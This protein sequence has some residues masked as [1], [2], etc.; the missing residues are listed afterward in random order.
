MAPN[1][2]SSQEEQFALPEDLRAW[3]SG[4]TL[5]GLVVEA[6]QMVEHGSTQSENDSISE[7]KR[8]ALHVLVYSYATGLFASE[9]IHKQIA[10]DP[11]LV[12]L[13]ANSAP[14]A[15]EFRRFRRNRRPLLLRTLARLLQL[16]WHGEFDSASPRV[17]ADL[18]TERVFERAAET[19]ITQ[20]A[21][22]D[23]IALD[24]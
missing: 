5:A 13:A 6:S 18:E 21:L 16:A 7:N 24:Y 1:Q 9:A 4:R 2:S 12:E 17:G 20:A 10:L 11:L 3:L 8:V 19:R 22:T 15:D 23:M 14:S